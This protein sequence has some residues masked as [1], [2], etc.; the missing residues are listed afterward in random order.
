[1]II[2]RTLLCGGAVYSM[3][4]RR[5]TVADTMEMNVGAR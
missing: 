4:Q 1:M 3:E 2:F 5:Y